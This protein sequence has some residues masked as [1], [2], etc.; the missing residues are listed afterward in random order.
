[1]NGVEILQHA[2]DLNKKFVIMMM[3]AYGEQELVNQAKSL[4]A[5]HFFKKPFEIIE[6]RETINELL[7]D[8]DLK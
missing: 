6:V 2:A 8:N 7:K 3:T 4:G 5:A 1:M